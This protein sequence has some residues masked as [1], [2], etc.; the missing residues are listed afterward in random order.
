MSESTP[1]RDLGPTRRDFSRFAASFAA[2]GA[3]AHRD[4]QA[5]GGSEGDRRGHVGW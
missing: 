3:A 2:V 5:V 1:A 4:L